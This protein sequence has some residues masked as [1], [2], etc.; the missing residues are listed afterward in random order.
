M[1]GSL[2]L[3]PLM[4]GPGWQAPP[5]PPLRLTK[6][7]RIKL[8][9]QRR[10]N[11]FQTFWQEKGRRWVT[12]MVI[13]M[14]LLC[15]ARVAAQDRK[16]LRIRIARLRIQQSRQTV[17]YP[18]LEMF[19][20]D[21]VKPDRREQVRE[22]LREKRE[23]FLELARDRRSEPVLA[24]NIVSHTSLIGLLMGLIWTAGFG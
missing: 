21:P 23:A 19:W 6:T 17:T 11:T 18:W 3:A 4:G 8:L 20:V 5:K 12:E 16:R 2:Q 7:G 14:G 15:T 9:V 10:A 22:L 24:R 13:V 1:D